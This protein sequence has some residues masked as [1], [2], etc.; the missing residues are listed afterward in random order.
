VSRTKRPSISAAASPLEISVSAMV[1]V[2]NETTGPWTRSTF[3]N[4]ESQN[5]AMAG[6]RACIAFR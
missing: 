2:W 1:G 3:E 4:T 5:A 6:A